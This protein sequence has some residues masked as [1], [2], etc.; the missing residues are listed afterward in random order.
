MM[1]RPVTLHCSGLC[2]R[3]VWF[4]YDAGYDDSPYQILCTTNT[5]NLIIEIL[6]TVASNCS[7]WELSSHQFCCPGSCTVV[8]HGIGKE[9]L[10]QQQNDK[11]SNQTETHSRR[12]LVDLLDLVFE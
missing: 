10:E 7:S 5:I 9:G 1:Y 11:K 4:L 8:A 2:A 3:L 12:I 6:I